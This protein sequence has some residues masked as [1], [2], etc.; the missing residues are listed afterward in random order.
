M[1]TPHQVTSQKPSFLK[2][3]G[4]FIKKLVL[5]AIIVA[6][7]TLTPIFAWVVGSVLSV[8]GDFYGNS[9][10]S[11]QAYIILGGGLTKSQYSSQPLIVL[12]N[13]SLLRT[14]QL[15]QS[16]HPTPHTPL[17]IITSGVESPWIIDGL[18]FF[19]KNH[20]QTLPL[21]VSENASMNTCENAWFSAKLINFE[22]QAGTLPSIH[23]AYLVSDW[24]HMARARRQFAKAGIYTTPIV[25]PMPEALA[26][27]NP[28]SNLNHARR[29]FYES[30]ALIRDIV[31]PQK[32]CRN[33]GD[34]SI[35]T[36]KTPRRQPKTF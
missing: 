6:A 2:R 23:H 10:G 30:M 22:S 34:I 8:V 12:N 16:L 28:K 35:D 4:R 24:Y 32:N 31:R 20:N 18:K 14:K 33:A 17:P 21:I 5:T 19:A 7:T 13:Y 11:P 36:L 27:N 29:A 15:W 9:E 25:A 1:I 3:I 26:W